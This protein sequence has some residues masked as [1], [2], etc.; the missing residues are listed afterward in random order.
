MGKILYA[1]MVLMCK[2]LKAFFHRLNQ[3]FHMTLVNKCQVTNVKPQN[4]LLR[5]VADNLIFH[6][7]K[8][9]HGRDKSEGLLQILHSLCTHLVYT[10]RPVFPGNAWS[11]SRDLQ[12]TVVVSWKKT[13]YYSPNTAGKVTGPGGAGI[14]GE[15]C[16]NRVK[17]LSQWCQPKQ[18]SQNSKGEQLRQL[19]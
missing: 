3:G 1:Y 6:T 14:E 19:S 7:N 8:L 4:I 12:S 13:A 2:T 5:K 15:G 17:S 16:P 10:W 11:V 18:I 9:K